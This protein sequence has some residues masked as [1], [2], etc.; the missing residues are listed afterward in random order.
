MTSNQVE[1][2]HCVPPESVHTVW[3]DRVFRI[4]KKVIPMKQE[5]IQ[6]RIQQGLFEHAWGFYRN[7]H[8]LV[9]KRKKK[10][11]FI[12]S[13]VSANWYTLEDAWISLIIEEFSKAFARLPI[14]SLIDF[15][16]GYDQT[17]L[18]KDS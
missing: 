7:A 9:P 6:L 3:Q 16:S 8:F 5:I 12:S 13:V 15:H 17:M 2:P 4:P 1:P 11:T 14:S 10:Y 18:H